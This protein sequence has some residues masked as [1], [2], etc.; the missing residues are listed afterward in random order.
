MLLAIIKTYLKQNSSRFLEFLLK[1]SYYNWA[2]SEMISPDNTLG[3]D[4]IRLYHLYIKNSSSWKCY[5]SYVF[6]AVLNYHHN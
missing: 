4:Y 3:P 5:P 1:N 6:N 2:H